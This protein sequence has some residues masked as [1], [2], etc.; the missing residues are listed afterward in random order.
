MEA[1][2]GRL[3]LEA[4]K[5]SNGVPS[6]NRLHVVFSRCI[7]REELCSSNRDSSLSLPRAPGDGAHAP[8]ALLRAL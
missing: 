1:T 5:T 3:V 6:G 2:V 7:L 8:A 4:L